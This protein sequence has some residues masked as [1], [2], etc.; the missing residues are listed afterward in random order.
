MVYEIRLKVFVRFDEMESVLCDWLGV[1]GIFSV[2]GG[3]QLCTVVCRCTF[4]YCSTA[5]YR[6][7]FT[8]CSTA[9]YRCTF[10][11]CSTAVCRCTFTYCSTAVYS[12]T[13]TYC[14]LAKESYLCAHCAV[15]VGFCKCNEDKIRR[16]FLMI[17]LVLLQCF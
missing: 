3:V 11:Y 6:Y 10:T 2:H 5:V 13:F 12:C 16:L 15:Y 4:T 14:I 17:S 9:V 8:Y 1:V 7:T